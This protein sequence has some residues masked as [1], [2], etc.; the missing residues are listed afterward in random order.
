LAN[1]QITR[2]LDQNEDDAQAM[3]A[4]L[5]SGLIARTPAVRLGDTVKADEVQVIAGHKGNPVAVP[6]KPA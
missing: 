4:Q 3:T 1:P 5:R 2:E 6:K